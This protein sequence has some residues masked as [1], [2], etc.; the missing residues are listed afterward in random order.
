MG[1]LPEDFFGRII[2]I[3]KKYGPTMLNGA[4]TTLIIAIVGTIIGCLI[5][6]FVGTIQSIPINKKLTCNKNTREGAGKQHLR[7]YE[8]TTI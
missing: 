5:G 8:Q 7:A 4:K 1:T 6:F 2:F 3:L